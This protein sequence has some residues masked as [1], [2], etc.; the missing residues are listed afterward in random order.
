MPPGGG[1]LDRYREAMSHRARDRAILLTSVLLGLGVNVGLDIATDAPLLVRWG[2]AA[3]VG[4]L[5]FTIGRRV[6]RD[7]ADD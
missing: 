4:L 1:H 5:V 2:A 6:I 3:A 7:R